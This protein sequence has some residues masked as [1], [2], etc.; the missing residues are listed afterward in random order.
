MVGDLILSQGKDYLDVQPVFDAY[1]R[2]SGLY[3]IPPNLVDIYG[4]Y[5]S[6][7]DGRHAAWAAAFY[8]HDFYDG[9]PD[10]RAK[11]ILPDSMQEIKAFEPMPMPDLQEVLERFCLSYTW[12][13]RT[14]HPAPVEVW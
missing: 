7:I 9:S 14:R 8:P 11:R 6:I 3:E 12:R 4:E 5:E 1:A 13:S 2:L 10:K